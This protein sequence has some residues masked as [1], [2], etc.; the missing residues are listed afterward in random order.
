M[1][2]E[3]KDEKYKFWDIVIKA[4]SSVL[5]ITTIV[6]AVF[7]Y[8]NN[9]KAELKQK[10]REFRKELSF[11]QI[12]YYSEIS[13]AM[14]ELVTILSYRD[15]LFSKSYYSRKNNFEALYFGKMNLMESKSVDVELRLFHEVLGKY[16]MDDPG[17]KI[18]DLRN[19]AFN[20]NNAFRKSIRETFDVK[21]D[22]LTK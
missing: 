4:V 1:K 21:L 22:S 16:E 7:T 9:Q 11:R 8:L 5:T 14:G 6:I 3:L 15:S 2:A 20:V 10:E 17:V 18:D 12:N 19:A 13:Q